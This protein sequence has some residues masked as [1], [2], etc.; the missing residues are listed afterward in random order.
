MDNVVVNLGFAVRSLILTITKRLQ[1]LPPLVARIAVG[2]VFIQSGWGKL[3]HLDKVV[4]FFRELGIPHPEAQAPFVASNELVFGA[5]FFV[6]LFT[7]FACVPLTIM[8]LV[9]IGTA[10]IGSI[11][12][13]SDLFGMEEFLFILI[14][15]WIFVSGPGPVS[16]DQKIVGNRQ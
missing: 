10:K 5:C 1:W 14:F 2:L 8:M 9:A 13:L 11:H 15:F 12:E 4:G 7:R 6:G 3:H 16:I